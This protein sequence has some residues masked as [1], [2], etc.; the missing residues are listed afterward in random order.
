MS[1]FAPAGSHIPSSLT[2]F[3]TFKELIILVERKNIIIVDEME[4]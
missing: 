2:S 3:L 1:H 4:N